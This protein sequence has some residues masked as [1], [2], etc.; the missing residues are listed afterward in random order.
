MQRTWTSDHTSSG[1]LQVV[2]YKK[3]SRSLTGSGRFFARRLTGKILVIRMSVR[4]CAYG[5]W[6]LTRGGHAWRLECIDKLNIHSNTY[7]YS[8][9][10]FSRF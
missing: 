4:S 6:S 9:K 3:K 1:R 8:F 5:R 2:K 10:I 7:Y